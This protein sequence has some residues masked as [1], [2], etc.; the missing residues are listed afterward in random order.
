MVNQEMPYHPSRSFFLIL[1]FHKKNALKR[2]AYS[3][4]KIASLTS[5]RDTM[6]VRSEKVFYRPSKHLSV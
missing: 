6:F 3:L 5:L 1:F 4:N 2:K